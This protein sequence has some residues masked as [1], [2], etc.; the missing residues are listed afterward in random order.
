MLWLYNYYI[1][2]YFRIDDPLAW[3]HGELKACPEW[4][5]SA[6]LYVEV[7]PAHDPSGIAVERLVT[8]H[9]IAGTQF[10]V[11]NPTVSSVSCR[12][13][14]CSSL[15]DRMPYIVYYVIVLYTMYAHAE[16]ASMCR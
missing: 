11:S 2:V 5:G 6:Y 13:V 3:I 14:L 1:V 12:H 15:F 4:Q 9:R 16:D 8:N 10:D 7:G